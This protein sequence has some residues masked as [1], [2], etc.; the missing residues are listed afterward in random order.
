MLY[1][2]CCVRGHSSCTQGEF[3]SRTCFFRGPS[4]AELHR[5]RPDVGSGGAVVQSVRL[6]H[7]VAVVV[8]ARDGLVVLRRIEPGRGIRSVQDPSEQVQSP[9]RGIP[10][11]KSVRPARRVPSIHGV[12]F[13]LLTSLCVTVAD[14]TLCADDLVEM[15]TELKTMT[16]LEQLVTA[17][18]MSECMKIK[19]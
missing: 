3:V 2:I 7:V 4:F 15:E 10:H 9:G 8:C 16:E 12:V 11:Q 13:Y 5:W 17:D 1:V 14:Q 6:V 18:K 19:T